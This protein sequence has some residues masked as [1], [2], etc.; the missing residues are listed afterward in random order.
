MQYFMD[1][2]F[3]VYVRACANAGRVLFVCVSI[4]CVRA[5]M[6]TVVSSV[7]VRVSAN[8]LLVS[9]F[10]FSAVQSVVFENFGLLVGESKGVFATSASFPHPVI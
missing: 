1:V 8:S 2:F 9:K 3:N 7:C 4:F 10:S 6:R 5:S